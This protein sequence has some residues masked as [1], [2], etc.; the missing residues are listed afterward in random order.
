MNNRYIKIK[1]HGGGSYIQPALEILNAIDGELDGL[2]IGDKITIDLE[3]VEMT[4][5][6]YNKLPEFTGH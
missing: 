5:E 1:L 6:E 3:L 2:E 4:D